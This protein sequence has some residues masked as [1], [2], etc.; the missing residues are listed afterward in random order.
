MPVRWVT[1]RVAVEDSVV[2]PN[3]PPGRTLRDSFW[4]DIPTLTLGLVRGRD[5]SLWLGPLELL[6]L[7]PARV[8]RTGVKWPIEGG[9]AARAPG[10]HLR[11]EAVDGRLLASV[12]DYEP[13]L[14][15]FL[16][17]LTQLPIHHLWTRLHLLR[18]RGR[19][20]AP[21][22]PADSRR[23][24]AAAAIDGGVCFA[25]AAV[26]GRR[27]RGTAI[28]FGIA[29][30]Y[31]VACWS[32]FGRT[33]GG[34]IMKQRVVAVD[35]SGLSAGQAIVRLVLLPLAAVRRRN[36]HDEIASTDVIAD[37]I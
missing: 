10:G 28:L 23:R 25:L 14:P 12:D 30:G 21:G 24:L 3:S 19:H 6:R 9:L 5:D 15:R 31:H 11:F 37:R 34:A 26:I 29:A 33:L 1:G 16:Y 2:M 32:L 13:L 20:P 22:V 8:T 35:G 36:V 4:A 17:V 7:G 27:R 18:V